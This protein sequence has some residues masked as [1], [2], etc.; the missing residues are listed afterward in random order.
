MLDFCAKV[1]V[2]VFRFAVTALVLAPGF[3]PRTIFQLII[4]ML[5]VF[6]YLQL[7]VRANPMLQRENNTF[8]SFVILQLLF[9]VSVGVR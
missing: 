7:I 2:L 5:F 6:V 1:V 9:T 8:N 4:G 3:K